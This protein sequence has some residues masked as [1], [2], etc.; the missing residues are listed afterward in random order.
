MSR[1]AV[2]GRL[3]PPAAVAS[4]EARLLLFVEAL[5][6]LLKL[7]VAMPDAPSVAAEV[8]VCRDGFNGS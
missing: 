6:H 4:A 7:L 5:S 3:T 1:R 2:D 8:S